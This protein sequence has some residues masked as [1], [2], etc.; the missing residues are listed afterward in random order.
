M[1]L[2]WSRPQKIEVIWLGL[3]TAEILQST[4][5]P[6][7][8]ELRYKFLYQVYQFDSF[9]GHFE[10]DSKSEKGEKSVLKELKMG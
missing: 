1:I 8:R 10:G 5:I 2:R 7:Y 9:L 4:G 6:P 3:C